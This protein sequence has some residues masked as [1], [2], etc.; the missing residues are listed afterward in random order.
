MTHAAINT[1]TRPKSNLKTMM[2]T[3]SKKINPIATALNSMVERTMKFR[4]ISRRRFAFNTRKYISVILT[5][6]KKM[7][8]PCFLLDTT[9]HSFHYL[10]P[11]ICLTLVIRKM[12]QEEPEIRLII[13]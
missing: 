8:G 2:F 5:I 7:V 9:A 10:S 4:A 6:I 11:I 12:K 1:F 13:T 3:I